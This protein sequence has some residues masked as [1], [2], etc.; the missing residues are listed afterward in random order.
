MAGTIIFS[1][2]L[3]KEDNDID[4]REF[5]DDIDGSVSYALFIVGRCIPACTCVRAC[6]TCVLCVSGWVLCLIAAGVACLA[7]FADHHHHHERHHVGRSTFLLP[8]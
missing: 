2:W 3:V 4:N 8:R 1:K 6:M 5:Q 7:F